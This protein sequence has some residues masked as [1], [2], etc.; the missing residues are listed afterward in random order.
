MASSQVQVAASSSPFGYV[1]RDRNRRDRCSP[2]GPNSFQKNLK[3]FVHSCISRQSSDFN[4]DSDENLWIGNPQQHYL[5]DGRGNQWKASE[6]WGFLSAVEGKE[7]DRCEILRRPKSETSTMEFPHSG[8]VSSLVR[9]WSDFVAEAKIN[10]SISNSAGCTFLSKNVSY[11]EVPQTCG[12]SSIDGDSE[13]PSNE[14]NSFGGWDSDRTPKSGPQSARAIDFDAAIGK[15]R[16]RV[17]DI[18]R[19]LSSSA[20]D[21]DHHDREPSSIN[22]GNEGSFIRGSQ[23]TAYSCFLMQ[24]ERDRTMEL[25]RLVE[26]KSVSKFKQR[27][28]IKAM[29]RLKILRRK[30][31][32]G[33]DPPSSSMSSEY[34]RKSRPSILHLRER[35]N[36]G[37]Q[38]SS[39]KEAKVFASSQS[40]EESHH[41]ESFLSNYCEVVVESSSGNGHVSPSLGLKE[42][43]NHQSQIITHCPRNNQ[44]SGGTFTS[45]T[46]ESHDNDPDQQNLEH[47]HGKAEVG[48]SNRS[49]GAA[50]SIRDNEVIRMVEQRE[51]SDD[52]SI[53]WEQDDDQRTM[54]SDSHQQAEVGQDWVSDVS[55]PRSEWHD[56]RQARYEEMLDPFSDNNNDIRELL[57]RKNVS[58]FL[59][60]SLRDKIDQMMISRTQRQPVQV[61]KD[62]QEKTREEIVLQEENREL[63]DLV[64]VEDEEE[65]YKEEDRHEGDGQ[66][67]E[68]P[69]NGTGE[70]VQFAST[71]LSQSQCAT[72]CSQRSYPPCCTC[73]C[74]HEIEIIYE[75]RGHMEQLHQEIAELRSSIKSCMKTQAKLQRLIKEDSAAL[76]HSD[77]KSWRGSSSKH[78]SDG[79][80]CICYE[81]KVDCLLYRC[82]HICT[83]FK[84]AHELAW[85]SGKCPVCHAPII[86]VVRA[87]YAHS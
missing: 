87:V 42:E 57:Q 55:R 63:E 26:L 54:E 39:G 46:L 35:F 84:C 66:I 31:E 22:G 58:N 72:F 43:D 6:D 23:A 49:I 32:I 38:H 81:M 86:D 73:H 1:L 34:S 13:I 69:D 2:K 45:T 24:V 74:S 65:D 10:N 30:P 79:N 76:S 53:Y 19:K 15:E 83:C 75:L 37:I 25:E 9:K 8:G 33:D 7:L 36:A 20:A 5:G 51:R 44:S 29:L 61:N 62:M 16:V 17:A 78:P 21:E 80:C 47:F 41:Q 70:D 11:T 4:S 68:Q 60:G 52:F 64:H 14:D 67:Q 85:G 50:M 18:V 56:L 82:G 27:G 12:E 3:G 71:S 59:S 48:C 77:Q 28:R 40:R